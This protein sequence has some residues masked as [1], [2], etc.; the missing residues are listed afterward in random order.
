M[1]LNYNIESINYIHK[2]TQN[3]DLDFAGI[4]KM[5]DIKNKILY[6]GKAKNLK[7]RLKSYTILDGKQDRIVNMI[8]Q[9]AKIEIIITNSEQEALL[10]EASL[11]KSIKPKYN[12]LL[13]DDKSYPFIMI[14]KNHDFAQI[15]KHRGSKDIK[16]IYFGPFASNQDVDNTITIIQKLFRLRNCSDSYFKNRTR[17]C[18][19]YQ[20]K[21]CSAPCM[22]FISKEEYQ[23]S[24][25][26][27]ELF[28]KGKNNLVQQ[29]LTKLMESYSNKLEFE[30]AANIRDQIQI[31]NKVQNRNL[32]FSNDS[33]RDILSIHCLSNILALQLYIFRGGLS[34]G[35]K[36]IV[37]EHIE[38][39]E[40]EETITRFL[41]NH[42]SHSEDKPEEIITNFNF[43]SLKELEK[44]IHCKITNPKIGEKK[45]ILNFAQNNTYLALKEL[46][47]KSNKNIEQLDKIANLLSLEKI[48]RIEAY[49]NSH[50]MG[51][52]MVGG[53]ICVTSNGFDKNEY[54]KFNIKNSS[55]GD[56]LAMMKE[57]L[58]RRLLRLKTEHPTYQKNIWPDLILIDGGKNQLAAALKVLKDLDLADRIKTIAIAKGEFRNK[59]D[60]TIFTD[61]G[62]V[63]KLDND[64]EEMK[65]IQIIRDEVHRY[66]ISSHRKI[67]DKK[68]LST[69]LTDIPGVGAKRRKLLMNYLGS[70]ENIKNA[71]VEQL[72]KIET[73]N[74]DIAYK[75]RHFF[76]ND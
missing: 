23:E 43:D 30:K 71:S 66:A 24:I 55:N 52:S 19:E 58:E 29:E 27:A 15:Q 59:G 8:M 14:R 61:T 67:R 39:E 57:V 5:L 49:D 17:P 34:Y 68:M 13:K 32:G 37:I 25:K 36:T 54:R 62:E 10:L 3:N 65:Y 21:R 47:K 48:Y 2:F 7:N 42:Y 41:I 1:S 53:M 46:I 6:I 56:D 18:L 60:E 72:C 16:N 33:S 28:I 63:I 40:I 75:I 12:I 50:I 51:T 38:E 9:I 76:G 35:N 26:Q 70:V 69:V 74:K 64:S 11:I 73:I 44:I 45:E 20:L 31:L 22:N 4:Y